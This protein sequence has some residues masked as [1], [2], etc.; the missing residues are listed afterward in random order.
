M[1]GVS[2]ASE[3]KLRAE[4]LK[5]VQTVPEINDSS[6]SVLSATTSISIYNSALE[7]IRG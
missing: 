6:S 1:L 2:D 3:R 4:V 7:L 5:S